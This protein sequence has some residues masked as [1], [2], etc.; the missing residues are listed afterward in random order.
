[1]LV[2]V[3]LVVLTIG[4]YFVAAARNQFRNYDYIGR[5]AEN[6]NLITISGTAKIVAVPDIAK[7]TIGLVTKKAKVADA[8][9]EN[10]TKMNKILAAIKNLKV[11]DKDIK[12]TAYSI[13]PEY[14]YAASGRVF[15]GYKVA[16]ALEV[17][18]RDLNNIAA[19][20][21]VAGENGA[22]NIGDL[23][24]EVDKIEAVKQSAKLQAIS[25]AK[26]KAEELAA[27]LGVKL[28]KIT[29]YSDAGRDYYPVYPSYAADMKL[30][31]ANGGG[32]LSAPTVSV[33]ENEVEADVTITFELL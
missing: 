5:T 24:F 12:T 29:G 3:A 26:T 30:N 7:V 16:Q 10:S 19:I 32:V 9:L 21:G 31:E 15:K 20:L 1:M 22:N 2:V 23:S 33:G 11:A 6:K 13:A 27:G 14:D 17:K 25:D 8:Q 4:F 18:I 28:G